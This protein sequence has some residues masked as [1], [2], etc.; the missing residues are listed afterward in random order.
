LADHDHSGDDGDGGAFD[1]A[2]LESG[3]ATDGQVL[4]AD[5]AG[6]AAWDDP[7]AVVAGTY[8]QFTYV[9]DGLG[10]WAFV[11]DGDGMPLFANLDVEE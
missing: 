4:T 7:E 9:P 2:N 10:S 8:R 6:G 11:V 5:G 3:A 1:A